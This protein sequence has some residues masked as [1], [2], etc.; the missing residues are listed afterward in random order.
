MDVD[1]TNKLLLEAGLGTYLSN[2][3]TRERCAEDQPYDARPDSG[4]R[5][6]RATQPLDAFGRGGMRRT[7]ASR[8]ELPQSATW[9][10]DW[11]GAHT[12]NAA[13]S[14]VTGANNMKFGYQGAYHVDNR[15]Q[16]GGNER[17]DL[18]LQQR[19]AE[20]VDAAARGRTAPTRAC[21]TTRSTRRTSGRAAG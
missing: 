11:I 8:P 14:Y 9:N 12:W 5:T 21:A 18:S 7:A 6:V 17:S 19:H 1:A 16:D 4:H 10:A 13:A 2:W 15:A 20:P 3:N